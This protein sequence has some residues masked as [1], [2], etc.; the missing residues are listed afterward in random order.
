MKYKEFEGF[1]KRNNNY[2][3]LM[4]ENIIETIID[5]HFVRKSEQTIIGVDFA[6]GIDTTVK[7]HMEGE[8]IIVDEITQNQTISKRKIKEAIEPLC[9]LFDLETK[10]EGITKFTPAFI[11]MVTK[12]LRLLKQELGLEDV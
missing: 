4:V 9:E 7:S 12:K 6:N 2:T 11:S 5:K 10:E 3:G 1:F 8:K